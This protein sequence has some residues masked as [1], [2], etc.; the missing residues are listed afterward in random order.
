MDAFGFKWN[1]TDT[2]QGTA[3]LAEWRTWLFEKYFDGDE[4]QLEALLG[5]Q[6]LRI[7]D[8]GCGAA[9]SSELLFGR[10]LAEHDFTGVDISD[11]VEVAQQRFASRGLPG[12][13]IQAD[14]MHIPAHLG[15]FD[16][17][18]SEGVLHHTDSVEEGIS[19]LGKR[20]NPGGLFLFYVYSKKAPIR[21][22]SDD[23]V[24]NHIS[25]MSN[26]EAWAELMPLSKLG[27]ALGKIEA[28]VQIEEDIPF[29]GIKKG[30][31]SVQRLLYYTMLKSFYH[32]EYS[33]DQLNHINFDWFRPKNCFRH[34]AEEVA[35]F[36]GSAGLELKRLHEGPSGITVVCRRPEA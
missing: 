7:L 20:L 3:F 19:T 29:L 26:E 8:A 18:F 25:E 11:A 9:V 13:F 34:T 10:H 6:K 36:V 33:L 32:P 21:E 14:L 2:Y 4:S 15:S 31:H 24:R 17:I 23:F 16:L 22:Y 1:K 35:K 30:V 27:Q 28:S 12:A 5:I